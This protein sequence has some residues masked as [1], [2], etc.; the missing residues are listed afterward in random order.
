MTWVA[1]SGCFVLHFSSNNE[2][3]KMMSAESPN[4]WIY[5]STYYNYGMNVL[6][7]IISRFPTVNDNP[8]IHIIIRG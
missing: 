6:H 3:T 8:T 4:G 7:S 5:I 2:Y 1:A